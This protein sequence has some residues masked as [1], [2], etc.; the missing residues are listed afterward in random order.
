ML[1]FD[2]TH[3]F[4]SSALISLY[5]TLSVALEFIRCRTFLLRSSMT[6]VGALSLV[7]GLCKATIVVMQEI[8]KSLQQNRAVAEKLSPDAI[9]G[10]WNRTLLLWINSTFFI[11]FRQNLTMENLGSLGPNF[12]SARLAARFEQSWETGTITFVEASGKLLCLPMLQFLKTIR[13][14][15]LRHVTTQYSGHF[16]LVRFLN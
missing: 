10:F 1:Y 5:C 2:H 14:R 7:I 16:L 12:S 6:A 4:R 8:P 15:C 11:G 3:A 13:T 9:A